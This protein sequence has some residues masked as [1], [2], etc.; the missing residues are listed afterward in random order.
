MRQ[1]QSEQRSFL[2]LPASRNSIWNRASIPT[3]T[4]APT[5]IQMP[6]IA[7]RDPDSD[8]TWP[9]RTRSNTGDS[10]SASSNAWL[11]G[12]LLARA[13]L[14]SALF[15]TNAPTRRQARLLDS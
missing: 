13:Q 15:P 10:R 1:S 2:K 7:D 14:T 12:C 6:P 8:L 3:T 9:D 4:A 11:C 5:T